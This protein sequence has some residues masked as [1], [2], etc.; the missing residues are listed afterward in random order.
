MRTSKLV[1]KQGTRAVK[2]VQVIEEPVAA[3]QPTLEEPAP[4]IPAAQSRPAVVIRGDIMAQNAVVQ[5]AEWAA[6]AAASRLALRLAD[7]TL[8]AGQPSQSLIDDW[9]RTTGEMEAAARSTAQRVTAE[10][11]KLDQL[12]AELAAAQQAGGNADTL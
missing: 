4:V 5:N 11:A 6:G 9:Q 3:E 7:K 8:L 2:P 1:S 10:R 12:R